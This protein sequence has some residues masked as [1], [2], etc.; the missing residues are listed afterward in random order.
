[1]YQIRYQHQVSIFLPICP[2]WGRCVKVLGRNI[3]TLPL[4]DANILRRL[5]LQPDGV[6]VEG[7]WV[8]KLVVHVLNRQS[9]SVLDSRTTSLPLLPSTTDVWIRKLFIFVS[10]L[11][12]KDSGN[13]LTSIRQNFDD[14]YWEES[15]DYTPCTPSS[16]GPTSPQNHPLG[17]RLCTSGCHSLSQRL[18]IQ[19][20]TTWIH[21]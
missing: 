1:M 2:A 4:E 11:F 3:D 8:V 5:A 17:R 6:L 16:I 15:D 7:G 9:S 20:K 13:D 21:D 18:K 14:R 19:M 10:L 12:R